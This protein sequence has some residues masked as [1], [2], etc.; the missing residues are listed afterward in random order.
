MFKLCSSMIVAII[1]GV[2]LAGN[3][4]AR[5]SIEQH[6][7]TAGDKTSAE[8]T[9]KNKDVV[10]PKKVVDTTKTEGRTIDDPVDENDV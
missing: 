1:L 7:A 6:V 2:V 9:K 8:V 4:F 3:A 10:Q 5:K